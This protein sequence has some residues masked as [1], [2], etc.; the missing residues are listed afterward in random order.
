M[1]SG[2]FVV[3][4]IVSA[5]TA[6]RTS[7]STSDR[8]HDFD[9]IIVL[10]LKIAMLAARHDFP[11]DLDRNPPLG[12]PHLLQQGRNSHGG[13]QGFFLSVQNDFHKIMSG[14]RQRH[15]NRYNERLILVRTASQRTRV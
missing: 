1:T 2:S 8:K 9:S 5:V 13:G 11:V 15:K 7:I 3:V 4:R 12:E 6:M 10:Q 14:C